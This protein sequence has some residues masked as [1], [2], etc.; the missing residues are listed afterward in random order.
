MFKTISLFFICY[1]LSVAQSK[2][3]SKQNEKIS[4]AEL[5][6]YLGIPSM[7]SLL[8]QTDEDAQKLLLTYLDILQQETPDLPRYKSRLLLF[9]QQIIDFAKTNRNK[10][11]EIQFELFQC[12]NNIQQF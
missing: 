9:S 12:I 8:N 11:L 6:E 7:D 2:A 5:K 3:Q 10:K 4:N 1:I